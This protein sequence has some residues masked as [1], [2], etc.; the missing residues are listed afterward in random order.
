MYSVHHAVYLVTLTE[1]HMA[2]KLAALYGISPSLIVSILL[3]GPNG[4]YILVTDVVSTVLTLV[5]KFYSSTN[6]F[7]F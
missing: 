2:E 1:R 7:T 6:R 4:I 5:F 3:H